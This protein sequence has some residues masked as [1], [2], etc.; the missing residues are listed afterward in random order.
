MHPRTAA[1]VRPLQAASWTTPSAVVVAIAAAMTL[2]ACGPRDE[3]P[4]AGGAPGSTSTVAATSPA[5][6]PADPSA[7]FAAQ[8]VPMA[9]QA[10]P[11][12]PSPSRSPPTSP[13]PQGV[14]VPAAQ[15]GVAPRATY[16]TDPA[17]G[18]R[19][20]PAPLPPA[21]PQIARNRIGSIESIEPIR[22]RPQ[23]SGAG[24]VVGGVLGAVVGNQFGHGLG[25]AALTGAGA[26]GGALAGN[27]VE[28]NYKE[29][30]AG[31]RVSI[32][33]DNGS[34][35]TFQRTQVGN[36]HV[37]DRVRLDANSFHRG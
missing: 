25:R 13:A 18:S 7:R 32:R 3:A 37:G 20:Q 19:A 31:Y 28:R 23:G 11:A 4:I 26:V 6:L 30:V 9:G 16:P 34:V 24:A 10:V 27:N 8:P 1:I 22:T 35:R 17:P 14:P 29:G 36:L 15:S 21:P 33:L 2:A 12:A 5:P